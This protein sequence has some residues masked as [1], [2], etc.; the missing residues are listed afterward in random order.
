MIEVISD[1]DHRTS[2]VVDNNEE[3][4]RYNASN[5]SQ[6]HDES[7]DVRCP[8]DGSTSSSDVIQSLD[9]AQVPKKKD[10]TFRTH[11]PFGMASSMIVL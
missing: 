7:G 2:A 9:R 6:S 4:E 10:G 1:N 3:L 8:S 11:F 5:Q